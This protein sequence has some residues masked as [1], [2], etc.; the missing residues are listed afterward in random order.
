LDLL[1]R[2]LFEVEGIPV[3]REHPDGPVAMAEAV[4]P[5]GSEAIVM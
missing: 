1:P 3:S 5:Q 4:G 2:P